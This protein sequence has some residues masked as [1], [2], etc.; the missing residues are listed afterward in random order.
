M[1]NLNNQLVGQYQQVSLNQA[2]KQFY[3]KLIQ[4][5][6]QKH[7]NRWLT[8]LTNQKEFRN[9]MQKKRRDAMGDLS[10]DSD[11]N[12]EKYHK[13]MIRNTLAA[14]A[15]S[16]VWYKQ[17]QPWQINSN[18]QIDYYEPDNDVPAPLTKS[19]G[20][21]PAYDRFNKQMR[22]TCALKYPK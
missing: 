14:N 22:C 9:L 21:L 12:D 4:Q 3:N 5:K 20:T 17:L 13:D 1:I 16:K 6:R 8:C 15:N 19:G 10:T 18:L 2:K 11:G 7:A